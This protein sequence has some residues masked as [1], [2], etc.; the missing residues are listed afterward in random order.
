VPCRSPGGITANLPD[1]TPSRAHLCRRCCA[2][3]VLSRFG[4]L[5]PS[6]NARRERVLERHRAPVDR[7]LKDV[8]TIGAFNDILVA[9]YV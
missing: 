1:E 9:D 8:S 2:A 6:L 5:T 7:L 3:A 4:E